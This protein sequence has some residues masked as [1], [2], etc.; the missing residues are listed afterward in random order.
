MMPVAAAAGE[1]PATVVETPWAAEGLAGTLACPGRGAVAGET[2]PAAPE[3]RAGEAP[4]KSA[5]RSAPKPGILIIAGSGPTDRDGNGPGLATDLYRKLAHGLASAGHCVLR[6]DKRGVGGSRA[7]MPAEAD[8][9]F[10]HFVGDAGIA[11]AGLKNQP[12][13][14]GAVLLGHSEGALIATL[15][16][17][18]V[19]P[20][21]LIL[22][23][24]PGRPLGSVLRSQLTAAPMPPDLRKAALD[25]LA[26]LEAGT[27]VS[28]VP[29]QLASLFRPSVQP[30]LMSQL[31]I[32]PAAALAATRMPVLLVGAGRDLQVGRV[33]LDRLVAARPEATVLRLP[34]ANHIL[35]PAP[36]DRAGNLALYARPEAPLDPALLPALTGFL[37]RLP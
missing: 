1:S 25:I 5:D 4:A 35:V 15:L 12:Q 31:R 18:Q 26:A 2:G 14:R 30:Y 23:A 32:D 17:P 20:D 24:A 34:E 6:Y 37:D 21:G 8:M 27:P 9:R 22:V 36:V 7:A 10:D 3:A 13:V 11:L 29:P 16:A 19:K 28:Q 33:D